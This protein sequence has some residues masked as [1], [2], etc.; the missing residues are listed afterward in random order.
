MVLQYVNVKVS[1]YLVFV[2][3][4]VFYEHLIVLVVLTVVIIVTTQLLVV[5]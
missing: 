2:Q 3:R 5:I 4:C 1:A